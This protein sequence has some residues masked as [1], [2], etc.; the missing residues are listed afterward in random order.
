MVLL[1]GV[2][3]ACA[4]LTSCCC[5]ELCE[6]CTLCEFRELCVAVRVDTHTAPGAADVGSASPSRPQELD[7]FMFQ[8]VGH[9]AID[10][11][12]QCMGVPLVRA[13]TGGRAVQ[14]GVDY[15]ASAADPADEVEELYRLLAA[16]VQRFPGVEAVASGAILSNYQRLRVENVCA[17]LGLVSLAFLWQRLQRRLVHDMLVAGMD[18]ALL[19]VASIGLKRVHVGQTLAAVL[20]T[21]LDIGDTYEVNVAGEGGEYETLTLDSP[22]FRARLAVDDASV[23]THSSD[24]FASVYHWAVSACHAEWKDGGSV[25]PGGDGGSSSSSSSRAEE[26]VVYD[27]PDDWVPPPRCSDGDGAG[28]GAAGAGA[29]AGAGTASAAAAGGGGGEQPSTPRSFTRADTV[30]TGDCTTAAADDGS[31]IAATV[32]CSGCHVFVGGVTAPASALGGALEPEVHAAMRAMQQVLHRHGATMHSATAFVRVFVDD[33]ADFSR[34]NGE[35]KRFFGANPAAR[36]CVQPGALPDGRRVLLDCVAC[37]D[38]SARST[39]HVQSMSC[40]AP[41]CIGP[42]CQANTVRGV[43]HVAGQIG[44][45]PETMR[46]V[47]GGTPAEL[48]LALQNL[49][50]VLLAVGSRAP[51]CMSLVAYVTDAATATA[52]DVRAACMKWCVGNAGGDDVSTTPSTASDDDDDDD[53][54]DSDPIAAALA[55]AGTGA[56]FDDNAVGVLPYGLAVSGDA[57]PPAVAVVVVPALPAGATCEIEAVAATTRRAGDADAGPLSRHQLSPVVVGGSR[58]TG[59]ACVL[60]PD[61][62]A[63]TVTLEHVGDDDAPVAAVMDGVVEQVQ[64]LFG[65]GVAAATRVTVYAPTAATDGAALASAMRTKT[66]VTVVKTAVGPLRCLVFMRRDAED[67]GT[68]GM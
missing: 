44:L 52:S 27:V 46:L 26:A 37:T 67:D 58:A 42:Y 7:S 34:V 39:L 6:L 1:L 12:A 61:A 53:D 3:R 8:T 60:P 49:G 47:D 38:A 2:K 16:V 65:G 31:P 20:P 11:L 59:T 40:W 35:Y 15:A 41:V 24:G 13:S 28:D 50:R 32:S 21:L 29:G 48:R 19:K 25:V 51:L 55:R 64:S 14:T 9:T 10:V 56:V 5:R 22:L 36:A 57:V 43:V 62:A 54:A 33:M 45:V 17:R 4:V 30:L 66:A 68:A 18:I 63:A 23:V